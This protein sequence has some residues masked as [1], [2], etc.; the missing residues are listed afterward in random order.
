M[1]TK[2]PIT[3]TATISQQRKGRRRISFG[4]FYKRN[5]LLC[6]SENEIMPQD[7]G[8]EADLNPITYSYPMQELFE[9]LTLYVSDCNKT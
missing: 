2:R 9:I 5:H 3:T 7:D 8:E 1:L 4:H 6:A